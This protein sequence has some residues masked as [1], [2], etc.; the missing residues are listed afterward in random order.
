MCIVR[1][2][3]MLIVVSVECVVLLGHRCHV[4]EPSSR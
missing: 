3:G 1:G 4:E 2:E